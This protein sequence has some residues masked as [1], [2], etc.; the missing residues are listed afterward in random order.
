MAGLDAARAGWHDPRRGKGT[1]QVRARDRSAAHLALRPLGAYHEAGHVLA[2]CGAGLQ[3]RIAPASVRRE[4]GLVGCV[5]VRDVPFASHVRAFLGGRSW[6]TRRGDPFVARA[7]SGVFFRLGGDAAESVLAGARRIPRPYFE[8]VF[9]SRSSPEVR[10]ALDVLAALLGRPP[11]RAARGL[12]GALRREF[13]RVRAWLLAHGV[14]VAAVAEALLHERELS[15]ARLRAIH[16]SCQPL[17][18][19][20]LLLPAPWLTQRDF[21]RWCGGACAGGSVPTAR[22]RR[23]ARAVRQRGAAG[24]S[25][26]SAQ[27]CAAPQSPSSRPSRA[28]LHGR[29]ADS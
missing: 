5:A 7:V 4:A 10:E 9:D 8:I 14:H 17:D 6:R 22:E 29:R 3:E 16:A 25:R 18:Q 26:R 2:A 12:V 23:L 28:I 15:P 19:D 1:S 20:A 27:G 11:P 24:L 13:D 21:L